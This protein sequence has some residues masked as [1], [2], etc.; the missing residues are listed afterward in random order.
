[1]AITMTDSTP[2]SEA[3]TELSKLSRH[4]EIHNLTEGKSQRTAAWYKEVLDLFERWLGSE[5]IP[6]T[7]SEL[8]ESN[9]R[10]FILHVQSLSGGKKS[11]Y[12]G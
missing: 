6:A 1:M 2:V 8:N 9:V 3:A 10:G 5:G 11:E 7:V 4:F 12:F